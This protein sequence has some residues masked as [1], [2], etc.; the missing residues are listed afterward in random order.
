MPPNMRRSETGATFV[1]CSRTN[2]L[3]PALTPMLISFLSEL[4]VA[5]SLDRVE[6]R[7]AVGRIDAEEEADAGG[8]EEG[9]GHREGGGRGGEMEEHIHQPGEPHAGRDPEDAPHRREHRG[10]DQEL[11]EDVAAPRAQ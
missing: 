11:P 8:G 7:R 4:L 2:W 5:Q 9:D 3:K 1:I 6:P 10:F